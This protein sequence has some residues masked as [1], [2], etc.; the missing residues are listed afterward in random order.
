MF[1]A[2][3]RADGSSNFARGNR[4]GVFPSFSAGWVMT[5]EPFM[6]DVTNWM[7]FLKIRASWGQNGNSDIANFQ[8]LSTIAFDQS[9]VLEQI[10]LHNLLVLMQIFCLMKIFHGKLQ[11][12]L[13]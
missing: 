13:T 1:S 5:N 4:W 12:S 9:Y 3:V 11:N 10:K 7:D 8:Y 2:T 6:E